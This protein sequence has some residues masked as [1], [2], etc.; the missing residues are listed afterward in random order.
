MPGDEAGA[1]IA[2]TDAIP[3]QSAPTT[4]TAAETVEQPKEQVEQPKTFTQAEL[5]ALVQKRVA[6]EQRRYN[7]EIGELRGRLQAVEVQRQPT[8]QQAPQELRQENFASYD[9]F[10]EAKARKAALDAVK[11]SE[12]Q[13][14]VQTRQSEEQ[15]R[16]QE[17]DRKFSES[18]E[19]AREK[20]ADY[21][22]VFDTVPRGV[23]KPQI[24]EY[25]GEVDNGAELLYHLAN[26]PKE[27]ARI[28]KLSPTAAIRELVKRETQI[29]QTEKK[30]SKAPP[31]SGPIGGRA[32]PPDDLPDASKDSVEEWMR[33]RE[34][35]IR[36][37][38]K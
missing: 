37:K 18:E 4:D 24:L 10:I 20:F 8:Q 23:L 34:A 2:Q 13:R 17:L 30:I 19:S 9:E 22:E 27:L 16:L 33:K 7:R 12:A 11:Q 3:E 29:E 6:R 5:D 15:K 36:A 14:E 38:R 32:A 26:E 1:T 28:A 21:D 31:P 25:L 35:M